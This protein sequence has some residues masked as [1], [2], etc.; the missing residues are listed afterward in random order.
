MFGFLRH[1]I[2]GTARQSLN[3]ISDAISESAALGPD[4]R[5]IKLCLKRAHRSDFNPDPVE[6]HCQSKLA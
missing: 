5:S 1:K 2:E 6:W 4:P 3:S